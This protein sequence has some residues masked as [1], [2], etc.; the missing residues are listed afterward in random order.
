[1]GVEVQT[2]AL[3]AGAFVATFAASLAAT[4]LMRR[5]ALRRDVVDAPDGGRKV[6]T[7]AIPYLGGVAIAGSSA[8]ALV[9]GTLV[10]GTTGAS[11]GLLAGVLLPALVLSTVGL[12][13]DIRGLSP[14]PRFLVQSLAGA[15]T[16]Y[17]LTSTGTG[18]TISSFAPLNV[19][20]TMLWVVGV[21]NALN[22]L[23]NTDGAAS[24]T[25]AIAALGLF[26][27][28]ALNGQYLVGG[29][30]IALAGSCLGFL[31]W[32]YHPA[33]IYMGDSGSLFIGF[34]LAAIA[35]RLELRTVTQVNALAVPIILLAVPIL[36]T[37]LVV[38]ARLR[39][40]VS[41]FTGGLDHLAHR[42]RRTGLGV[43]GAVRW[44]WAAGG[45]AG[46]AA[47]AISRLS[48]TAGAV[49]AAAAAVAFV[50][51]FVYAFRLPE[52]GDLS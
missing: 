23:D 30:A 20:L 3:Y 11:I 51:A 19:L 50:A 13:D 42:L 15:V 44:I 33:R 2:G 27:I 29:L 38:T 34:M 9:L 7:H 14:L 1:M 46:L 31:V 4:P 21:T 6:Q 12:W 37:T 32:N 22:L 43:R 16:A 8:V 35:I 45:V 25:A 41:P 47:T 24:G 36:D 10:N 40:G 28:A 18:T 49:V 5:V 17:I 26:A 52:T 48:D 39:R